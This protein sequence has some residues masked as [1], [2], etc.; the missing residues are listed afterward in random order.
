MPS[1]PLQGDEDSPQHL[2]GDTEGSE[3]GNEQNLA[4]PF[5]PVALVFKDIHYYVKQMGSDLELLRVCAG[6]VRVCVWACVSVCLCLC[7]CVSVCVCAPVRLCVCALVLVSVCACACVLCACACALVC[8][9]CQ[10]TCE[11]PVQQV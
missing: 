10:S 7:L 6:H 1:Q 2:D 3:A 11:Y 4:L 5:E 8:F 9:L